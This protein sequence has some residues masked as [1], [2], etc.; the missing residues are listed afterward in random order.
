[1]VGAL[2]LDNSIFDKAHNEYLQ[3]L[4]TEGI[5]CFLSY[6]ALY[7]IIFF[8]GVKNSIKNKELYLILPI[9]GYI[10][11]AFFNI[12]VIEVA[13][14]FYMTLGLCIEDLEE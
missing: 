4:V 8:Y 10:V 7:G 9:I 1:M 5:F 6:I 13:P 3:I 12:S 14:I 2:F 11:Q